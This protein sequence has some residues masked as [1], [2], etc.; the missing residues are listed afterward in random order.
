MKKFFK[1]ISLVLLFN[2]IW[3]ICYSTLAVEK[4]QTITEKREQSERKKIDTSI[5]SDTFV[6]N[7]NP[8]KTGGKAN[9]IIQPVTKLM[10]TVINNILQILQIIGGFLMVVSFAIM[11]FGLIASGNGPLSR[12]LGIK[13]TPNT[14][15]T[16]MNYGRNILIGSVLLFASSTIVL[17]VYKAVGQ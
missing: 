2:I 12:D 14:R 10:K 3:G 13:N 7:M 17:F 16:L 6:N 9:K 11:G 1:I 4:G 8:N 5:T 15:E